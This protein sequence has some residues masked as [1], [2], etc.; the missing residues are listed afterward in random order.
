MGLYPGEFVGEL[1]LLGLGSDLY[2]DPAERAQVWSCWYH[3][4]DEMHTGCVDGRG[5]EEE[6]S[7]YDSS[8]YSDADG[9]LLF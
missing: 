2:T 6:E 3:E 9:R 8:E 1:M 4:H 5:E 7:G